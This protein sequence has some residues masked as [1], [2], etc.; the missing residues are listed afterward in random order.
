MQTSTKVLYTKGDSEVKNG[1][2]RYFPM[3]QRLSQRKNYGIAFVTGCQGEL[4]RESGRAGIALENTLETGTV[5]A[6]T[7]RPKKGEMALV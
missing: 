1:R 2:G 7:S 3:S 5:K 6:N 4:A